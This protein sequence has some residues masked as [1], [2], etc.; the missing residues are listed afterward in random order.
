MHTTQQF[1]VVL[2]NLTETDGPM[3]AGTTAATPAPTQKGEQDA[4]ETGTGMTG[5]E[6]IYVDTK[7]LPQMLVYLLGTLLILGAAFAGLWLRRK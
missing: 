6:A 7:L 5:N 1:H 2:E 3:D 4:L